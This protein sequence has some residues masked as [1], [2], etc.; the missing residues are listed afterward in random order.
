MDFIGGNEV[1][2]Q[3]CADFVSLLARIPATHGKSQK[4][5]RLIRQLAD[6]ADN[7]ELIEVE[8]IR[9]K[10]TAAKSA[11]ARV[12][13]APLHGRR[14]RKVLWQEPPLTAARRN[15]EDRVRNLS[16]V[17]AAGPSLAP[18]RGRNGAISAHSR[19]VR[20]LAYRFPRRA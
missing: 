17:R 15:V 19:S 18:G 2:E 9:A 5:G 12:V 14:R 8:T 11:V 4:D 13:E 7:P 20:S 3:L 6:D 16:Q 1:T 10:L